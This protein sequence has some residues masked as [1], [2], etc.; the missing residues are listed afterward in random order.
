MFKDRFE[1]E[2]NLVCTVYSELLI[3]SGLTVSILKFWTAGD[4]EDR[5]A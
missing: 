5:E 2:L 3:K 4:C 1:I